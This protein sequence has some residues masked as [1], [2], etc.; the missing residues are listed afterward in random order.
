MKNIYAVIWDW[1]GTLL[2]DVEVCVEAL[3]MVLEKRNKP[4]LSINEYRELFG[5]PVKDYYSKIG[6]DFSVDSFEAISREFMHNYFDGFRKTS[7]TPQALEGIKK[8]KNL[9]ILQFILSLMEHQDLDKTLYS[10]G[11]KHYF[12]KIYGAGDIFANSKAKAG[13]LLLTREKLNPSNTL[14]IGDTLHDAEV[15]EQIG[16]KVALIEGGHNSAARLKKTGYPVYEDINHL[17][18][19]IK[20]D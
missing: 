19:D 18:A 15:G 9:G 4:S 13:D 8:I 5:F 16:C 3:N 10:K 11:I 1:N 17:I 2:N 7:L 6:L 20:N 12:R 14:L